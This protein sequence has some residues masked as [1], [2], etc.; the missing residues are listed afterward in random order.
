[1]RK[2]PPI[3]PPSE[4]ISSLSYIMIREDIGAVVI[5]D[6]GTPVGII[7]EKDIL[8]RVLTPGKDSYKTLAK[9]VMSEPLISIDAGQP[10]KEALRIMKNSKIRRLA[11][12]ENGSLTGLITERR[13]LESICDSIM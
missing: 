5:V 11:V 7:T 9:D 3:V 12:T 6:E 13:L 1:M 4:P 10:V 8:E 2:N